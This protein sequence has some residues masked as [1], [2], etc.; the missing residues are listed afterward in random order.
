MIVCHECH[1][2]VAFDTDLWSHLDGTALCCEV[3]SREV[4]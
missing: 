3:V 2:P 1:Q 4:R